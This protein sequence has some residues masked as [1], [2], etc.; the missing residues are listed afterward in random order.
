M[1]PTCVLT[2]SLAVVDELR[3]KSNSLTAQGTVC[4]LHC[5]HQNLAVV[6]D[7]FF[8]SLQDES[9]PLL[10]TVISFR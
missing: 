7:F 1:E 8:E 3:S 9:W 5:N 6:R 10:Q 2:N 4:K